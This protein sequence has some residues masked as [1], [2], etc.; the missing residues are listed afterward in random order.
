MPRAALHSQ[1]SRNWRKKQIDAKEI[2]TYGIV[3]FSEAEFFQ[4]RH[5]SISLTNRSARRKSQNRL[6]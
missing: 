2:S 6:R 4:A 5:L 1:D 3:Q